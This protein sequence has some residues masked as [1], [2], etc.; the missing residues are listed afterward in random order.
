MREII[1]VKIGG[2]YSDYSDEDVM[3]PLQEN[4]DKFGV[5]TFDELKQKWENMQ[6]GYS[7][8]TCTDMR[9]VNAYT[10]KEV[11]ELEKQLVIDGMEAPTY[12]ELEITSE[13][14]WVCEEF[15]IVCFKDLMIDPKHYSTP[16]D[17]NPNGGL[18]S[19]YYA[20]EC[21]RGEIYSKDFRF[22]DCED[23]GRTI[24]EQNPA[25]GW[26]TQFH[27]IGDE[28]E[29]A[30]VCSKCWE[31]SV[32][33]HGVDVEHILEKRIITG[34]FF[35][36]KELEE[37][38]WVRIHGSIL[39]GSGYTGSQSEEVFFGILKSEYEERPNSLFLLDYDS[40]AIGGLGGYVGIWVK[41]KP[42]A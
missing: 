28:D 7:P 29:G 32:M 5:E 33:E 20:V 14:T 38:G 21:E 22:F 31:E 27:Y 3:L 17:A 15:E 10:S 11:K 39:V 23:C 2:H 8:K 19:C 1:L 30:M 6:W 16:F 34:D 37:K 25:N 4:L 13:D 26:E 36:Y 24:C 40:M 9:L 12:L 41:D 18:Y 35:N 42:N